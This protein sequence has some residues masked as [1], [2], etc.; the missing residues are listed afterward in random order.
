VKTQ[1]AP[2]PLRAYQTIAVPI[3]PSFATTP[4]AHIR[5]KT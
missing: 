3:R 4:P 2:L 5:M 1:N